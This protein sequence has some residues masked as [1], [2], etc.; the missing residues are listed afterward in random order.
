MSRNCPNRSKHPL[1]NVLV[2]LLCQL[3]RFTEYFWSVYS[4]V[5]LFGY[6]YWLATRFV[7]LPGC[8]CVPGLWKL[9]LIFCVLHFVR[10]KQTLNNANVWWTNI[11]RERVN[12]LS[13]PGRVDFVRKSCWEEWAYWGP[14]K[15]HDL[16]YFLCKCLKMYWFSGLDKHSKQI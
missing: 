6:K 10:L 11:I 7:F 1:V 16:L 8:L 2:Q 15:L 3:H 14:V 5:P 13:R 4:P 12:V 9:K